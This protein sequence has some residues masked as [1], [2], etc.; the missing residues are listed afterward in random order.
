MALVLCVAMLA[1]CSSNSASTDAK[2][3][4]TAAEEVLSGVDVK[5]GE[6]TYPL[7]VKDSVGEVTIESQP[8]KIVSL[9]PAT[10][11][12]L[13]AIGVGDKVVGDTEYCNYPEAAQ[14]IEK[15]GDF[16]TPNVEKILALDPDLVVSNSNL[17]DD[18]RSQLENAGIKVLVYDPTT[19]TE[20]EESIVSLGE[21]CGV[22]DKA[23]EVVNNMQDEL[24]SLIDSL[25]KVDTDKS[26][27]IDLGSY[28][29]VGP[30]SLQNN[31]LEIIGA[32]NIAADQK[33]AYPVLTTE[34]IIADN[35]DV[36]ISM[37][38]S[39]D[40]LKK[41]SGFDKI[42]AFEDGQAYSYA[43]TS[44]NADMISRPGPRVVDGMKILA[45]DIYPDAFK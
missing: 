17:Q 21:V 33:T 34:Q 43:D 12:D 19:V 11:E 24:S 28:Y 36:Y 20:V 31:E 42:K 30:G 27:F 45:Q 25:K 44:Q 41:V 13:F 6:T 26:V 18:V 23:A 32:T 39:V 5:S 37:Y 16:S 29:T 3:V 9:A 15:V 1:G 2:D 7:T 38:T 8:T 22:N 35:P 4:S 14:S 10:T 40:D